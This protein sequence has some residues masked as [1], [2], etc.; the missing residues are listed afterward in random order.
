MQPRRSRCGNAP[1]RSKTAQEGHEISVVRAVTERLKPRSAVEFL[2]KVSHLGGAAE[3]IVAWSNV[4]ERFF[5]PLDEL[6]EIRIEYG[7]AAA[8]EEQRAIDGKEIEDGLRVWMVRHREIG[9]LPEHDRFRLFEPAVEMK[10]GI[11]VNASEHILHV[12]GL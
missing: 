5:C 8:D 6:G 9:A 3:Q 7:I 12:I 10:D 11:G 4:A 2:L 1:G